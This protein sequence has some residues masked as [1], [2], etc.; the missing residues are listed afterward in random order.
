M[1]SLDGGFGLP[2]IE[3]LMSDVP[4]PCS[5]NEWAPNSSRRAGLFIRLKDWAPDR[6]A[7]FA[8]IELLLNRPRDRMI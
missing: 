8:E 7:L 4:A 3:A 5:D 2:I 1:A 6:R